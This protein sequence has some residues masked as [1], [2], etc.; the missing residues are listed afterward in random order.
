M[1]GLWGSI[2][3]ILLGLTT[4]LWIASV[5]LKNTSIIDI[6]WG[7]GFVIGAWL[8]AW[9]A[10]GHTSRETLALILVTVWGLRL[11]GYLLWRNAGKGEDF[12]YQKFRKDA[13]QNYWWRSLFTVFWLQASMIAV[14]SLPFLVMSATPGQG[15]IGIIDG[16]ALLLWIVGFAF[17][18]GGD[19]QLARFRSNTANRGKVMNR[20]FWRFTRHPN[21][22]GDAMQWWAY[23]LLAIASG[24]HGWWAVIGPLMMTFL[25]MRVS[26]VTLLEKT[27]TK[28]KPQYEAYIKSTPAFFPRFFSKPK[29]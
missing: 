27:L 26:G 10:P 13:G 20:G 18:A 17:E 23:G 1:L 28:S 8:Y 3:L 25:L 24:A 6:F 9:W 15:S 2:F 12:R 16:I 5:I 4:L 19:W 14:I 11:G 7:P 29:L 22:F 21:Y